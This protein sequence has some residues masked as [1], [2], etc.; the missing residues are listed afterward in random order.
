MDF[1]ILANIM[2]KLQNYGAPVYEPT[3]SE[4]PGNATPFYTFLENTQGPIPIQVIEGLMGKRNYSFTDAMNA[5][6]IMQDMSAYRYPNN[7][8]LRM[9]AQILRTPELRANRGGNRW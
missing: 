6:G 3:I 5:P 8:D 4:N 1:N 9:L 7:V 2:S